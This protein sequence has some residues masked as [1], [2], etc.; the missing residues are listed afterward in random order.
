[1]ANQAHVDRAR[2]GE[3]ALKESDFSGADLSGMDFRWALMVKCDF[4]GA[5]LAGADM[6]WAVLDKSDF[7]GANLEGANLHGCRKDGA[8]IDSPTKTAGDLLAAIQDVLANVEG[9]KSYL[10]PSLTVYIIAGC[11]I[12]K[13]QPSD[14]KESAYTY[15]FVFDGGN[16]GKSDAG[17]NSTRIFESEA[18]ETLKSD[19]WWL[20]ENPVMPKYPTFT[21]DIATATEDTSP[22]A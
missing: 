9:H 19:Y 4:T 18:G 5:N 12:I 21:A 8:R 3:K 2:A 1:M 13:G 6:R 7:S 16:A 17:F 22:E 15:T 14:L 20:A 11:T 10:D